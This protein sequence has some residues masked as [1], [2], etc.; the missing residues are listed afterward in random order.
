LTFALNGRK[1]R[2]HQAVLEL[3]LKPA[4]PIARA[5]LLPMTPPEVDANG[6]PFHGYFMVTI[7]SMGSSHVTE[8]I[9]HW[10]RGYMVEIL[11][12]ERTFNGVSV[13]TITPTCH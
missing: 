5:F 13:P 10:D 12:N 6:Y 3:P 11:S 7:A 2:S 8:Q 9:Q 4:H 1:V